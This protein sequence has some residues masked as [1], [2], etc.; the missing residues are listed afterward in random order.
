MSDR[1]LSNSCV[2][3]AGF[4][5]WRCLKPGATRAAISNASGRACDAKRK[6]LG[7]LCAAVCL[8][9]LFPLFLALSSSS[10]ASDQKV[11]GGEPDGWEAK[12]RDAA[13]DGRECAVCKCGQRIEYRGLGVQ[14]RAGYVWRRRGLLL[15]LWWRGRPCKVRPRCW[16]LSPRSCWA[17]SRRA[18]VSMAAASVSLPARRC[19][20]TDC[21]TGQLLR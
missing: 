6:G 20:L 3:R 8:A 7:K 10:A 4:G 18:A 12:R 15:L 2:N 11:G 17:K 1:R 9:P 13:G 14:G 5:D 16:R 19:V 21:R